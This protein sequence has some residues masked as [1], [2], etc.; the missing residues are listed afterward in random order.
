MEVALSSVPG[1]R[2]KIAHQLLKNYPSSCVLQDFFYVTGFGE[3]KLRQ[4][5]GILEMLGVVKKV[6]AG[7]AHGWIINED[8]IDLKETVV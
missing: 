4:E 5:L 6:M 8:W 1:V 2:G 7:N 3:T